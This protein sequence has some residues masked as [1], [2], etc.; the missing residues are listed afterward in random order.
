MFGLEHWG[1][2]QKRI[3]GYSAGRLNVT[4]TEI[5]ETIWPRLAQPGYAGHLRLAADTGYD[6]NDNGAVVWSYSKASEDGDKDTSRSAPNRDAPT[7]L[8]EERGRTVLMLEEL[9]ESGAR[10]ALD[11]V[12][13]M[14]FQLEPHHRRIR[15]VEQATCEQHLQAQRCVWILSD[16]GLATDSFVASVVA[17]LSARAGIR[18]LDAFAIQCDEASNIEAFRG[19]AHRQ[20][21]LPLQQFLSLAASLPNGVLVLENVPTDLLEDRMPDSGATFDDVI[22][23]I[24]D[25]CPEMR[26]ILT[27][28]STPP[29]RLPYIVLRALELPE[30]RTYV[31]HHRNG[32]E[33]LAEPDAV[34]TLYRRSAGLPIHLDRLLES[35]RYMTLHE[36]SDSELENSL[37]S[38][39]AEA[40]P[41]DL[42]RAVASLAQSQNRSS[43]RSFNLLKVL[44]V[45]PD[46]ETLQRIKHFDQY[47]PFFPANATQLETL[48]LIQTL[49]LADANPTSAQD[50]SGSMMSETEKLLVAPRQVRDYVRH[51]I[52]PTEYSE[53]IKR[54]ADIVFG[55]EWRHGKLKNAY[56]TTPGIGQRNERII[57][58]HLLQ[59]A[60]AQN[61]ASMINRAG[62]LA[63]GVCEGLD[64]KNRYRETIAIAE[65]VLPLL[66]GPP[67]KQSN[68]DVASTNAKALRMLDH[69]DDAI[70]IIERVLSE[71]ETLLS[72]DKKSTLYLNLALAHQNKSNPEGT[73]EAARKVH[74]VSRE[75]SANYLQAEA[76]I[77]QQTLTGHELVTEWTRL[78]KIARANN[79]T[80]VA[81][82]IALDLARAVGGDE[83]DQL[84]ERV[85]KS[86]GD[87]YN[88][89]RG[90][91]AKVKSQLDRQHG[92]AILSRQDRVLLTQAYSYLYRQ[93]MASLFDTCHEVLWQVLRSEGL[94]RAVLRLFRHSSFVWRIY[95]KLSNERKYVKELSELSLDALRPGG[96]ASADI[97]YFEGRRLETSEVVAT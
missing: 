17:S 22:R 32:G 66:Q 28:R 6:L 83:A 64:R 63:A 76:I 45:L 56:F 31:L 60:I 80:V 62:N 86:Q 38:E 24:L 74:E 46:G 23:S 93:R 10:A 94:W 5:T 35:L 54:A 68:L 87:D 77:A 16:W 13:R 49:S 78:E 73:V 15:R 29:G 61:D 47:E 34:D 21:G 50:N 12:P 91:I 97:A 36:L 39:P 53:I 58:K 71:D 95:G 33:K 79:C 70:E 2:K 40:V 72:K 65:A 42:E 43:R 4:S 18:E 88:H 51:T 69:P 25:Y 52:H 67:S 8:G 75:G 3:H 11:R 27:T 41:R 84:R 55:G 59:D 85:I 20:L 14:Q 30:I 19:Q 26:I 89:I 82:N 90:V 37:Q 44:I 96:L 9:S 92:S 81:N 57:L 48:Q 1:D 7:H